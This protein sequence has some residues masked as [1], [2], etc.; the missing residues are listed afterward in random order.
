MVYLKRHA[1][2][3]DL[4]SA[5]VMSCLMMWARWQ[6]FNPK[7]LIIFIAILM[8]M[9]VMI[10]IRY[11][12]NLVCQFCGFDP[13]LYKKSPETAALMVK[14]H[15]DKVQ[16]DPDFLLSERSQNIMRRLKRRPRDDQKPRLE[17]DA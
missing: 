7:V 11:R 12:L 10:Q 8:L 13:I 14:A 17:L 16:L 2:A 4:L 6:Q 15:L 9:E 1:G 3:W 5:L